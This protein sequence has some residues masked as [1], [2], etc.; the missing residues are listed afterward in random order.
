MIG[1]DCPHFWKRS[2]LYS[3]RLSDCHPSNVTAY[4]VFIY[5]QSFLIFLASSSLF[6]WSNLLPDLWESWRWTGHWLALKVEWIL[7]RNSQLYCHLLR[8]SWEQL[9]M[10]DQVS[11]FFATGVTSSV[12]YIW[13]RSGDF[14]VTIAVIHVQSGALILTWSPDCSLAKSR[15]PRPYTLLMLSCLCFNWTYTSDGDL[16]EGCR[17]DG[18]TDNKDCVHHPISSLLGH[19]KASLIGVF[20][21]S[22]MA[23]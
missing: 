14:F 12:Y 13:S 16:C 4:I 19:P 9:V 17:S 18:C 1:V 22:S 5:T 7:W 11:A 21:N 15:I 8:F 20:L 23:K 6:H 10:F 2:R 3:Y